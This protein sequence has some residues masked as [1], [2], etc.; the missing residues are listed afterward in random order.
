M[1]PYSKEMLLSFRQSDSLVKIRRILRN[2]L[3]YQFR[4]RIGEKT[5]GSLIKYKGQ[6]V[7]NT[8]YSSLYG[9]ES[10]TQIVSVHP[11]Q[12]TSKAQSM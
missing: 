4:G 6:F 1:P 9:P 5:M 3:E 2:R 12:W 7:R 10:E 11:R 8:I